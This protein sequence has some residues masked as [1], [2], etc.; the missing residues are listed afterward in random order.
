MVQ[1]ICP[2]CKRIGNS[3][4]VVPNGTKVRCPACGT[5]F[6]YEDS[7][8]EP[9]EVLP[10]PVAALPP[11]VATVPIPPALPHLSPQAVASFPAVP[12]QQVI[13]V[14]APDRQQ[15]NSVGVA[16]LVLGIIAVLTAWVPFLGLLAIP[17]GLIGGLLGVIGLL[18]GLWSGRGKVVTSGVG[19]VLSVGSILLSVAITGVAAKG[20]GAALDDAKSRENR[21]TTLLAATTPKPSISKPEDLIKVPTPSAG[22]V[23]SKPSGLPTPEPKVQE[24]SKPKPDENEGWVVVPNEASDENVAI[25]ITSVAVDRVKCKIFGEDKMSE[26]PCLIVSLSI[27]NLSKHR[28]I[29][30]KSWGGTGFELLSDGVSLHDNFGNKYKRGSFDVLIDIVGRTKE[31]SIYPGKSVDDVLLF[32]VPLESVKRL[33]LE[34][35][36]ENIGSDKVC[37]FRIPANLIKR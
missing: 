33:D 14:A 2:Q 1:I 7:S 36:G 6:R 28:K 15:S 21:S 22:E 24:P 25:T 3:S 30:Y 32:E 17:V 31:A 26:D 10:N 4:K 34:L 19:L 18:Y 20:I 13:Q 9:F 27:Y 11:I 8:C 35:P 16:A 5:S 12:F 29:D 37:R 23:A